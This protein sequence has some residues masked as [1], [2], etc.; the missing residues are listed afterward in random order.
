MLRTYIYF[1][2]KKVDAI[3]FI[4][5]MLFKTSIQSIGT[6]G[7]IDKLLIVEAN[8]EYFV[9]SN[10][11]VVI[12]EEFFSFLMD[13]AVKGSVSYEGEVTVKMILDNLWSCIIRCHVLEY[14]VTCFYFTVL[15][16]FY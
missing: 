13:T 5:R 3:D 15:H 7:E 2:A 10:K 4:K 12:A 14:S 16:F 8:T 9:N 6:E 1:I 11:D